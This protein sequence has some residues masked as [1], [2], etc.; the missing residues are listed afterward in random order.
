[1]YGGTLDAGDL[2]PVGVFDINVTGEAS[3]ADDPNHVIIEPPLQGAPDNLSVNTGLSVQD[4]ATDTDYLIT[5]LVAQDDV[6]IELN[7]DGSATVNDLQ[8]LG[9]YTLIFDGSNRSGGNT[10][11]VPL[12]TPGFVATVVT[13]AAGDPEVQVGGGLVAF[14]GSTGDDWLSVTDQ[15]PKNAAGRSTDTF[16]VVDDSALLGLLELEGNQLGAPVDD[17]F[18]VD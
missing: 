6:R 4:T 16:D 18:E 10:L 1:M 8:T 3:P 17:T 14:H 15:V 11:N 7:G 13:D 9:P 12:V 5:G 2:S